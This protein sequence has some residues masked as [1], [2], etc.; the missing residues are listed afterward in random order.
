VSERNEQDI[1]T[2]NLQLMVAQA[3]AQNTRLAQRVDELEKR[4]GR[5]DRMMGILVKH[6]EAI[7]QV[8]AWK[9]GVGRR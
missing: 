6:G 3:I 1:P 9:N 4:C 8:L 2:E 5:Y 7:K